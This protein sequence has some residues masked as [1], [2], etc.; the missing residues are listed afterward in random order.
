MTKIIR[1]LGPVV[2]RA[3][4]AER[5][6]LAAVIASLAIRRARASRQGPHGAAA[7]LLTACVAAA[8]AW[9]E[10]APHDQGVSLLKH[11]S[12]EELM[13]ISVTSVSR[14]SQ[15][16]A[17]ATAALFVISR[18]DIRRS[19]ATNIPELLRMV[20]GLQV[21]QLDANKW[22]IAA[23]GFNGRHASKLLVQMDGRTLYT[24]F[25]SG[26]YWDAQDVV[27]DDIERIEV[28]RGP[29]ATLWGANAVN[30][31]INIITR[32]S[33]DTE[34]GLAKLVVG[35]DERM[36][37]A[38]R[39]GHSLGE[40]KSFRI[41]AKGF[42]RD[43]SVTMTGED[44]A[45]DW[46]DGRLGFRADLDLS[47][48]DV[49]NLQGDGYWGNAGAT[50]SRR[51][52]T[53]ETESNTSGGNLLARWTRQQGLD[54]GM[55]LKAY[56]DQ[57]RRSNWTLTEVRDIFDVD[58]QQYLTLAEKHLLVWGVGYRLTRDDI[59]V[60][61]G[62]ALEIDP[63]QRNDSTWS[64]FIQDDF[65]PLS[66]NFH[67]IVGSKFE[68]NDYT[69]WEVMPTIRMLWNASPTTNVWAAVSRAVRITSRFNSD[70]YIDA[71]VIVVSGNPDL[72][73]ERLT[74]YEVGLRMRPTERFSFDLT[75]FFNDYDQLQGYE[76]SADGRLTVSQNV[77]RGEGY[78]IELASNWD[79]TSIWRLKLAYSWLRMEL[80]TDDPVSGTSILSLISDDSAPRN[81]VSLRSWLDLRSDLELDVNFYYVDELINFDT[82]AY[83]RLD[84]RLGWQVRPDLEL[85]LV[86]KNLLDDTH[87][88]FSK[89]GGNS[90]PEGLVYTQVERSL[91]LQAKWFF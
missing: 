61:T 80:A 46:R 48:T 63:S 86:G 53:T 19:G 70:S 28:I 27:L 78:G 68:H 8:S 90:E 21:A 66:D 45:D 56:Y 60:T 44:A 42:E 13:N 20:P 38:L 24:P 12:I 18:E 54:S 84:I 35:T 49:L 62:S 72:E 10:E 32:S 16:Y 89:F 6:R 7:L 15:K 25:Y 65:S 39:Y 34:G 2:L 74:A 36:L 87:P 31:I 52:T 1:C 73:S 51:G 81:Q 55:E 75:T 88:E 9:A 33:H 23:R 76:T 50:V 14:R 26:V 82:A 37:G 47:A 91:M 29:G 11:M 5:P 22:A 67:L 59:S 77:G 69:G 79:V 30:G 57:T 71:G 3:A 43:S 40:G 58:F 64:F 85:S 4:Q 83:P 17:D 41:S